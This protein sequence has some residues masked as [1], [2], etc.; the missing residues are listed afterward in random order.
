MRKRVQFHGQTY[1]VTIEPFGA[2][3]RASVEQVT[4]EEGAPRLL[5]HLYDTEHE[6]RQAVR[7]TFEALGWVP[8]ARAPF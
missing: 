4:N 2:A 1:D 6:A 3:F 5:D 7:R 8:P